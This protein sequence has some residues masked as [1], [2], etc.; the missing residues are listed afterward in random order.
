[1]ADLVD[2]SIQVCSEG[3]RQ[4][5]LLVYVGCMYVVGGLAG[6]NERGDGPCAAPDSMT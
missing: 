5:V 4:H 6:G 1:M 3:V 2:N